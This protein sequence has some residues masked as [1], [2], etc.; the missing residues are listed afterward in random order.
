[1]RS[2]RWQCSSGRKSP[3]FTWSRSPRQ[4]VLMRVWLHE[5]ASKWTNLSPRISVAAWWFLISK[6][7][8]RRK[9]SSVM[10]ATGIL[11]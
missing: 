2:A 4:T 6:E 7:V 3:R 11:T 5:P 8:I 10:R 9:L 1:M